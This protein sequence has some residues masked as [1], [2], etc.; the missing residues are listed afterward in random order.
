M[1]KFLSF[2]MIT[3]LMSPLAILNVFALDNNSNQSS[4]V[5]MGE[6]T[7]AKLINNFLEQAPEELVEL[8]NDDSFEI[9]YEWFDEDG[10]FDTDFEIMTQYIETVTK[11]ENGEVVDVEEHTL[12]KEEYDSYDNT[13]STYSYQ[14][15]N[16]TLD[17]PMYNDCWETNAKR[18]TLAIKR[19]YPTDEENW[20]KLKI[21]VI[22]TWK[23]I[24]SVKSYDTIGLNHEGTF[25]VTNAYGYQNWDGNVITYS[26]N[27]TNMKKDSSGVSISQNIV[28]STTSSLSNILW[29]HGQFNSGAQHI[30]ASYQHA[31]KNISLETSKDF[32][33]NADGM[34]G[35]FMWNSSY[36][37]WDNMR[38]VCVN[39][40]TNYL[41][42]C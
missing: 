21:A 6:V 11:Y 14:I 4:L 13:A 36:S 7:E 12:T 41:W 17:S 28:D 18:L 37:N 42:V 1:K 31:V 24:P 20:Q 33:F 26:Y 25:N 32:T 40:A 5:K 27:G 34:G 10:N 22:N 16:C 15:G 38:G 29:V 35:V 19:E 9:T 39:I 23:T 3:L 2:T 8:Y 30:N